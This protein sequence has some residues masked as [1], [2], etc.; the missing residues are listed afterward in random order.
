MTR[1]QDDNTESDPEPEEDVIFLEDLTP[2][3]DAG[4]R[5]GKRLFGDNSAEDA[6]PA[7]E[8]EKRL[9]GPTSTGESG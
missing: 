8:T 2:R 1:R 6:P 7:Q 4:V 5:G 9:Q 3:S